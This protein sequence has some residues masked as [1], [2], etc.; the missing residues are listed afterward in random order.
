MLQGWTRRTFLAA[1]PATLSARPDLANDVDRPQY[2]FLP[3]SNWMNDPNAP[4]WFQGQYHMFYQYNPKA[5]QW[6]TMHWGHAVSGDM[7]H[8]KH[9]PIALAP[10]PG[11]PDKDGCFTGCMVVENGKPVIVYTGVQPE[12]QCLARSEDLL[13][14]TKDPHN[15][16]IAGPPPVVDTP[17]FRDPQVW[18]EG[19]EW[20]LAIGAGFRGKGGTV[21]MYRSDD[22]IQ[23]AYMKPLLTGKKLDGPK[24]PVG[25][26]EM[27]ECPDFF[28]VGNKW[29][30]YVSTQ[31]KVLYWLGRWKNDEFAPESNGVLVHGS[32][33]APKSCEAS[34]K[35]RIIWAWLRE[36]RSKEDQLR[37]G[38]SGSMSLAVVP[39]LSR[40]GELRLDPAV[41]YESLRGKKMRGGALDDCC[42]IHVKLDA[43]RPFGLLR[44]GREVVAYDPESRMLVVGKTEAP[45][46]KV[47]PEL[48][49]F[50]DGSVVEVFVNRRMWVTGRVYGEN[51]GL[52]LRGHPNSID[53]WPLTPVSK[54]RLTS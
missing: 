46:P 32:G 54:D 51:R 5:A 17:G 20:R 13:T 4:V 6:D 40:S 10:T 18:R 26:G 19:N 50:L 53:S 27:W 22:L 9:L 41:E 8:W 45:M 7:L 48:R 39:S 35:R 49:I 37:A 34:G 38:W 11:G 21:L 42:E 2:H 30:L 36:Q 29:L 47:G 24:D 25:S 28:P 1:L 15:P 14:W 44:G 16:V 52:S 43:E 3:P 12:V 33:Y 31:D 23:W